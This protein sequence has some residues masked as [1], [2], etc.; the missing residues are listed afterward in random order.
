MIM[1]WMYESLII[2]KCLVFILLEHV[3][4]IF[5]YSIVNRRLA[6]LKYLVLANMLMKSAINP[7]DSQEVRLYHDT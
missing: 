6:C 4:I 3:Y 2:S 5:D 1:F 7:F